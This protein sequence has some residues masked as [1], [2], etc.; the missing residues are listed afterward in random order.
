MQVLYVQRTVTARKSVLTH[1]IRWKVGNL[2]NLRSLL[3]SLGTMILILINH[4]R[5]G[6]ELDYYESSNR[7]SQAKY[8]T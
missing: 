2:Y 7:L 8:L 6:Y 3:R 4:E 1:R 5:Q